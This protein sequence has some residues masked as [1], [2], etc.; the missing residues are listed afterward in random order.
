MQNMC[1]VAKN[2]NSY[3]YYRLLQF[4]WRI[5]LR[6]KSNSHF[7]CITLH[8]SHLLHRFIAHN[9]IWFCRKDFDGLRV[10]HPLKICHYNV[11]WGAGDKVEM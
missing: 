11:F 8:I 5:I 10:L 9:Q 4:L 3:N 6:M 1:K 7:L 2:S